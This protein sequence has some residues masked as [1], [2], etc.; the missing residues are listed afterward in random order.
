MLEIQ[1]QSLPPNHLSLALSHFNIASVLKSLNRNEECIKHLSRAVLI[2][3][4]NTISDESEMQAYRQR[5]TEYLVSIISVDVM[6]K[7]KSEQ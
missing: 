5:L 6:K 4:Q 7:V 2:A 1:L 3:S